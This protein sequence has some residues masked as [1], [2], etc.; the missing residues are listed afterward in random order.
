[1]VGRIQTLV[2]ALAL[3]V[4]AGHVVMAQ[5]G[6]ELVVAQSSDGQPPAGVEDSCLM[7]PFVPERQPFGRGRPICPFHGVGNDIDPAP[8]ISWIFIPIAF[9]LHRDRAGHAEGLKQQGAIPSDAGMIETL[10][11]VSFRRNDRDTQSQCR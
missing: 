4:P 10:R 3:V 5:E 8:Q 1:M 11:R 2:L 9:Q 7:P 6:A